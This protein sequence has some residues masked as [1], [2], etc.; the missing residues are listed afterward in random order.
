MGETR[1]EEVRQVRDDR[2]WY[3]GDIPREEE[4]MNSRYIL[5]KDQTEVRMKMIQKGRRNLR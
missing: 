4:K 5:E 2:G 3:H 1:L